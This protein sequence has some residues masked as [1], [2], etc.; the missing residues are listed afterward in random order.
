MINYARIAT[1]VCIGE[2]LAASL[3]VRLG[4]I[5]MPMLSTHDVNLHVGDGSDW[6]QRRAFE[7]GVIRGIA[8]REGNRQVV[9]QCTTAIELLK[10]NSGR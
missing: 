8:I 10:Q 3:P 4:I 1:C 7:W 5:E 2:N 9:D 6:E